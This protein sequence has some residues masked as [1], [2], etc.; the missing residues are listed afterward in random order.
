MIDCADV[1]D[2]LVASVDHVTDPRIDGDNVR[3]VQ[4]ADDL[5]TVLLVGVVHDHPASI[6]RVAHLI[7]TFSADVLAVELPPL[8]MPLFRLYAADDY[9]PPRMGGEMSMALQAFGDGR[10]VGIDAPNREYFRQL[11]DG[12]RQEG[13][14]I[15]LGRKLLTSLTIGVSQALTCR[16]GAILG[17]A[18]PFRL[19][20]Y[21]VF[22]HEASFL[23]SPSDQATD[24]ASH[25]SQE[26]AL[27][28]AIKLPPGMQLIENAREA[29]MASSLRTLRT[30][31]DVV[32]IVG[33]EHLETLYSDLEDSSPDELV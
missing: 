28:Q 18:T 24:E 15:G 8:A 6:Y 26:Q 3:C 29:S 2:E 1:I 20:V 27:L 31:G 16:F 32:A 11:F 7:E 22:R 12:L 25:I 23:D 4:G 30:E 17:R 14:S 21:K 9:T 10:T 33:R 19:R 13:F 5:G